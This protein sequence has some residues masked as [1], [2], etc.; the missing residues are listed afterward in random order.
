MLFRSLAV[1]REN[2]KLLVN[3][4]GTAP[5]LYDLAADPAENT[6]VAPAHPALAQE[7]TALALA[8]KQ[9]WPKK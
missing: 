5:E 7:L 9:T 3:A 6:N 8:W 2:W 1:H 4:D